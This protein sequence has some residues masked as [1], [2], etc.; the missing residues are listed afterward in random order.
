LGRI[1]GFGVFYVN[2]VELVLKS[3]EGG[4]DEGWTDQFL[5]VARVIAK[6][7]KAH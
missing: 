2:G 4:R 1:K 5:L 3:S 7:L 6:I